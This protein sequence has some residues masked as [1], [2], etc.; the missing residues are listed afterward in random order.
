MNT[1]QKIEALAKIVEKLVERLQREGALGFSDCDELLGNL[2]RVKD[3][4][5]DKNNEQR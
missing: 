4:G 1:N 3:K 2:D 5:E